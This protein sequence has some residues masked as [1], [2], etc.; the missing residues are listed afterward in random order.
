MLLACLGALGFFVRKS[1]ACLCQGWFAS[2]CFFLPRFPWGKP[3]GRELLLV[4]SLRGTIVIR[5][6]DIPKNI[7]IICNPIFAKHIWSWLLRS[8]VTVV[9]FFVVY[10]WCFHIRV[11]AEN[12]VGLGFLW[13]VSYIKPIPTHKK[14]ICCG[15]KWP[16]C[17]FLT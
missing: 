13:S 1:Q 9:V 8:P 2:A 6:H 15:T 5:T 4:S 3:G 17:H 11:L 12:L 10:W 7:Y 14:N 16:K